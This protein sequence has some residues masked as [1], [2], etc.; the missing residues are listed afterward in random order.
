MKVSEYV[1]GCCTTLITPCIS[2]KNGLQKCVRM[3]FI[4]T[5]S[6]NLLKYTKAHRVIQLSANCYFASCGNDGI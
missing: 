5:K 1:C 6:Q 4:L 3:N 2:H